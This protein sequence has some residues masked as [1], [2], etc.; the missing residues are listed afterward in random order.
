MNSQFQLRTVMIINRIR[1]K[2]SFKYFL[3]EDVMYPM[4]MFTD[5]KWNSLCNK[6]SLLADTIEIPESNKILR[7]NE[8]LTCCFLGKH[9]SQQK[10]FIATTG[11]SH[12]YTKI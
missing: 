4:F 11:V 12:F 6:C 3:V 2:K 7:R 5:T 8:R 10:Y 9:S 1:K